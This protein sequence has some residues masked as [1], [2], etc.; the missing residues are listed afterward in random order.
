MNYKLA[1]VQVAVH[2]GE[3]P[4]ARL[5]RVVRY[6]EALEPTALVMLPELWVTSFFADNF[7]EVA[8]SLSGPIVQ[9]LAGL[10][11]RRGLWLHG[12][13]I[14]ERDATGRLYNTSLLFNPQGEL[15]A[16]YRKLHLFGHGSQEAH[17]ITRGAAPTVVA[18]P[19]GRL[20]LSTCYDLRFPELY[21][22]EV[23]AGAE[24]LLLTAAW[25]AARLEHWQTL[26]RARAIENQCYLVACNSTGL[27]C[28]AQQLGYSAVL[29]PW[30][31]P[32]ACAGDEE[33][34]L[35]A[36]IDLD[37][38]ARV[39]SAFPALRDRVLQEARP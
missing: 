21:R 17:V 30:G 16:T 36:T 23:A 27:S 1:L 10:A 19:L 31:V 8:E 24:V 2:D 12:G 35:Y 38:L 39:R 15:A 14:V 5:A 3:T 32:I 6:I 18:T 11:R 37:Y 9:T 13:S 33:T 28:G 29:N 25:P 20:G 34:A 22:A 4:A 7:A 26:T